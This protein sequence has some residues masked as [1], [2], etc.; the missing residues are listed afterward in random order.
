M[1]VVEKLSLARVRARAVQWTREDDF[2]HDQNTLQRSPC[3][4]DAGTG[5]QHCRRDHRSSAGVPTEQL[6]RTT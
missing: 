4:G 5:W 6:R 3:Q 1:Q 2:Q